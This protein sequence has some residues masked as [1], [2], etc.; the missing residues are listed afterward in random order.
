MAKKIKEVA[1]VAPVEVVKVESAPAA[2]L[3]DK[4]VFVIIGEEKGSLKK[5]VEYSVSGN[6][7]NA[8]IAKG[9]AKLKK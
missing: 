7:A 3:D 2:K 5:G 9:F 1:E 4:A 8:L 6:I